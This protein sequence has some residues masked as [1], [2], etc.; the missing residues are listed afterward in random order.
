MASKT[1]RSPEVNQ[2][3]ERVRDSL[4][5]NKKTAREAFDALDTDH[6]GCLVHLDVVRL[7]RQFVPGAQ[8]GGHSWWKRSRD[9]AAETCAARVAQI[10]TRLK[11]GISWPGCKNSTCKARANA[12]SPSFFRCAA[13]QCYLPV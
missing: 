9:I 10:C 6:D 11:S 5:D 7:V 2:Q 1:G 3:L 8:V 13:C 12:P 4:R